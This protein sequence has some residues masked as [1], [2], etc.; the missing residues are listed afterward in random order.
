[1]LLG[2]GAEG[3]YKAHLVG[4]N[5]DDSNVGLELVE[6]DSVAQVQLW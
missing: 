4:L 1:M 2:G 3:V 6:F 5:L